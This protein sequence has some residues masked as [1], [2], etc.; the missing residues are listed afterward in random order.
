MS[1]TCSKYVANWP[2]Q[3]FRPKSSM[4]DAI[5]GE[6]EGTWEYNTVLMRRLDSTCSGQSYEELV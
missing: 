2:I 6:R 3:N 1:R 5:F 4:K